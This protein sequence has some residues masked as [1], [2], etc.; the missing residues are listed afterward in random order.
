MKNEKLIRALFT[1]GSRNTTESIVA[2]VGGLAAGAVI[3]IL[4]APGSG[5]AVRGKIADNL[6]ELIGLADE[7]SAVIEA[8]QIKPITKKPKSDIKAIIH[9]AHNAGIHTE[10][11]TN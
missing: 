4:F 7:G 11:A 10:Q 5:K 1:S 9:E 3:G 2:L 6:K 8:P